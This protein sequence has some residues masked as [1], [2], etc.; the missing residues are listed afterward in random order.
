MFFAGSND[1]LLS[2]LARPSLYPFPSRSSAL[3]W[4]FFVIL[5]LWFASLPNDVVRE[6]VSVVVVGVINVSKLYC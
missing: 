2:L 5:K 3:I 4:E 6:S 1:T